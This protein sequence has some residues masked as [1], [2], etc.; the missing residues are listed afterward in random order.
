MKRNILSIAA[1][2]CL[3]LIAVDLLGVGKVPSE[4]VSGAQQES[5]QGQSAIVGTA[6][7]YA[8]PC[9]AAPSTITLNT[10]TAT[11]TLSGGY[12]WTPGQYRT[13]DGLAFGPSCY[14]NFSP[15]IDINFSQ[16]V[17]N[18]TVNI[19][20]Y[21]D[22]ETATYIA[23]SNAGTATVNLGF[24]QSGTA[25]IAGQGITHISITPDHQ[26]ASGD[27]FDFI[28]GAVFFDTDG[29]CPPPTPTPTPT[30]CSQCNCPAIPIIP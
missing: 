4:L 21:L 28:V 5:C 25:T 18:V 19:G 2:A 16:P 12:I 23:A 14:D 20:S 24:A 8:H 6:A 9:F 29:A 27:R 15:Q 22:N 11:V 17:N 10:A 7:S 30:P 13:L 3:A 26:G 1:V